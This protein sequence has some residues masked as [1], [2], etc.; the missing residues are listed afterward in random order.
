MLN[1]FYVLEIVI[2]NWLILMHSTDVSVITQGGIFAPSV[3]T[4]NIVSTA[5]QSQSRKPTMHIEDGQAAGR[6][7]IPSKSSLLPHTD[8]QGM[9]SSS[10]TPQLNSLS[11]A[12]AASEQ[13]RGQLGQTAAL[14]YDLAHVSL[15]ATTRQGQGNGAAT[16]V[17]VIPCNSTDQSKRGSVVSAEADQCAGKSG[18]ESN[19][20]DVHQEYSGTSGSDFEVNLKVLTVLSI[21]TETSHSLRNFGCSPWRN[22]LYSFLNHDFPSFMTIL[23]GTETNDHNKKKASA[24]FL[25]LNYFH[26]RFKLQV[27]ISPFLYCYI[28]FFTLKSRFPFFVVVVTIVPYCI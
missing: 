27:I 15:E 11:I 18:S 22:I 21:R 5:S 8:L 20:T 14:G 4:Q 1:K 6:N 16:R 24:Y 25:K 9:V 19:A 23:S 12:S 2:S 10:L 28:Y 7:T 13:E 26:P 17:Q 3:M